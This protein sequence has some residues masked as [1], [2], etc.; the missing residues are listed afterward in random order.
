MKVRIYQPTKTAMQSGR[1]KDEWLVEP[2]LATPRTPDP[3]MGWTSAGDTMN[4]LQGKLRF[5][6]AAAAVAFAQSKGWEYSI[7][8]AHERVV[9][10]KN[11]LDNFKYQSGDKQ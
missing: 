2:D 10:P 1:A 9:T 11:Y 6:T 3:L 7:N 8:I 5:P 4:E